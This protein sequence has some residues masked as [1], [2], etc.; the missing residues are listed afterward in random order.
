[1]PTFLIIGAQKSATRWLRFNLHQHPDVF[2]TPAELEFFNYRQNFDDLG[3][4]WYRRQLKG[5]AGE[6]AVGESTPGYMMWRHDPEA[7]AERI[8][9]VIP[10]VRLIAILRNPVDRAQSAL[11][12]QVRRRRLPPDAHLIDVVRAHAPLDDD[13]WGL[14][15]GGW[16]ARSLAPFMRRF[17]EQLLVLLH[18]DIAVDAARVYATSLRHLG[19]DSTFIPT[20]LDAVRY[21]NKDLPLFRRLVRRRDRKGPWRG[22]EPSLA[23]REEL[24][25]HFRDE[26]R[27]LEELIGRDLTSWE[28]TA[29]S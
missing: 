24:F 3:I 19:V 6:S 7:V 21:S 8:E 10:D 27:A 13:P 16:Y 26:V 14:V 9:Q 28:P 23:E 20:D 25:E 4:E 11:V 12:H 2:T 18:D 17:G 15:S 5:W 29:H 22:S 1:L